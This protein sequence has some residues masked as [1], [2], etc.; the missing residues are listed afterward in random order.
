MLAAISF[1]ALSAALAE[2]PSKA[3][4]A[5]SDLVKTVI[6]N[7]LHPSSTSNIHWKYRLERQLDGRQE[8]KEVV[9]TKS[10][11]LEKL[12]A[13]SGRPLTDAQQRDE[14]ERILRF[15]HNR[16]EQKKAEQARRKDAAQCDAFLKMIPD[17]FVFQYDGEE[18]NL[19]R[20][21]FNPNPQFR[22]SS[23]EPRV[24]QQMAGEMWI[25]GAQ[26][27]LASI[28]GQLTN[29]VKFGGGLLGHLEKGGRF[30]VK[31]AELAAGDWETTEIDV[32]MRGKALLFKSISV[33]QKE[34]HTNFERLPNDL[35]F[36]DA[37]N[38]L[39]KQAL[40]ASR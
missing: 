29:E 4:L 16:D 10:G 3:Q 14:T 8:T 23:R 35:T 6:Y 27:R 20:V 21:R 34:L 28:D 1:L 2:T 38:L 40:V 32:N 5:P 26:K 17:A 25:D 22:A 12:L 19:V 18:G 37:V 11:S 24:L 33:Q 31:R 7:E 36:A 30:S 39:L 13:V 15:S 9:E